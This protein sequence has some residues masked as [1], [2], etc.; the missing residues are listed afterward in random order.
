MASNALPIS[1]DRIFLLAEDM[2][3]G[4][5][6][7]ETVVGVKQF[8]RATL[9]ML[10]GAAVTAESEFTTARTVEASATRDRNIANSNVKGHL[11]SAKGIL[12]AFL[13]TKPSRAWEELGYPPG[14]TAMPDTMDE[15]LT[16]LAGLGDY[17][18]RHPDREITTPE[19]AFTA[20]KA[21]ALH[22]AFA[23]AHTA[24]HRAVALRVIARAT[25]DFAE[26]ALRNG[27]SGL[28]G[29]LGHLLPPD[30]GAWYFFGLVPPAGSEKPAPP[31]NLALHQVGPAAVAIGWAASP[32]AGNY[33]V[34][35]KVDGVDADFLPLALTAETQAL[36]D[37]LPARAT[38][39]VQVA[40]H[41]AA[42]DSAP[43][44]VATLTLT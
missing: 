10:F 33:R 3:D 8:T 30:A 36:L 16:V 13:G 21:R 37:E 43:G 15:R 14:T 2:L 40:A 39:H 19:I 28:V 20:A 4:L 25:R 7:K 17:L 24:L 34:L 29:E 23:A 44:P 27:M 6:Q 32:R 26:D 38:V 11:A 42:G 18:A 5:D 12:T 22:D 1:L 35:K 9:E 41:N 31:D